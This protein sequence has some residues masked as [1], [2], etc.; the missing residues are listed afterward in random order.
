MLNPLLHTS[1]S[2]PSSPLLSARFAKPPSPGSPVGLCRPLAVAAAAVVTRR[3][4][5]R[6]NSA[7]RRLSRMVK[8]RTLDFTEFPEGMREYRA[9]NVVLD[10]MSVPAM[11]PKAVVREVRSQPGSPSGVPRIRIEEWRFAATGS[12]V[13]AQSKTTLPQR[14]IILDR[15]YCMCTAHAQT[16]AHVLHEKWPLSRWRTGTVS[17]R[18]RQTDDCNFRDLVSGRARATSENDT[19]DERDASETSKT[20]TELVKII[21]TKTC[22]L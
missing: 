6:E 9:F 15:L 8:C 20:S 22:Y 2:A 7:S 10:D 21:T 1:S 16:L 18:S 19:S 17:Q 4:P 14:I 11:R 12:E 3:A 13:G 5:N